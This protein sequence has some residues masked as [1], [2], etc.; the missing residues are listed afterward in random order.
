MKNLFLLLTF[1]SICFLSACR[2]DDGN[3]GNNP[4]PVLVEKQMALVNYMGATWC[5]PCGAVGNSNPTASKNN[6]FPKPG[7]SFTAC[8]I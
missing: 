1:I 7:H 4:D 6:S 2:K 8:G 3:D 5:E